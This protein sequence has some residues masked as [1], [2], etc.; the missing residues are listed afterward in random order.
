[1]TP[2]EEKTLEVAQGYHDLG[3]VED[4]WKELLSLSSR[5]RGTFQAL[6]IEAMLL[7][8]EARYEDALAVARRMCRRAPKQPSG[9]I[10]T[11]F[12]MH[13]LGQTQE[14]LDIL[15]TGPRTLEEEPVYFYNMSCYQ[16]KLGQIEKA[17]ELLRKAMKMD[18]KFAKMAKQ[19]PD[20]KDLWPTL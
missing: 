16:A 5:C 2:Q 19:D 7:I 17:D 11:A 12:C 9:Y 3:M 10:H 4:A 13:E 8:G 15:L 6:N 20:L 14:A 1:M 18:E